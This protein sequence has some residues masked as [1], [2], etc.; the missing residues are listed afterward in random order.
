MTILFRIQSRT[1]AIA[2]RIITSKDHLM[3]SSSPIKGVQNEK[4]K[5][6]ESTKVGV[7]WSI[8][9]EEVSPTPSIWLLCPL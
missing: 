6:D 2:S 5:N 8:K 4:N 9:L 7:I 3:I 1:V